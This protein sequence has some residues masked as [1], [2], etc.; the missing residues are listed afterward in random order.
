MN[1][2]ISCCKSGN[3]RDFRQFRK[4]DTLAN[5]R[6]PRKLFDYNSATID[7]SRIL[8][9]TKSPKITNLQKFKHAKITRSTVYE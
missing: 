1:A 5:L 3:I 6:I 8:D 9:L 7:N 4:D 2:C